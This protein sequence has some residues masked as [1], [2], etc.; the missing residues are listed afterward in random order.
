MRPLGREEDLARKLAQS[1]SA[2]QRKTAVV[3]EKAYR[4]ILTA[5]QTRA[6]LEDQPPG[7]AASKLSAQQYETLVAVLEEYAYNMP[8]E[9]A[10]KRMKQV[11]D[12][13]KDKLMFAW[14]GSIEPG[15]GDYYRIQSPTFL[16]EYDN[17]QNNNNHS[18]SVWRDYEG[19]FGADVLAMHYRQFDHGL[20]G[21]AADD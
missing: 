16:V 3:D 18:H 9:I 5:F 7:I 20:R 19:D 10:A 8:A 13:P 21:L 1:L 4:D 2:D 15:K 11:K 17:T 12:T 14:A 6:K